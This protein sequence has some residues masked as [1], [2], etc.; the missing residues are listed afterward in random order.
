MKK[1]ILTM[2]AALFFVLMPL[3]CVSIGG[4]H[5]SQISFNYFQLI[6]L[7]IVYLFWQ[8]LKKTMLED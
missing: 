8:L 2:A 3:E 6:G 1:V 7:I 4:R 5:Y